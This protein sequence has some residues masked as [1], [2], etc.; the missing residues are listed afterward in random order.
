[1]LSNVSTWGCMQYFVKSW[2][3]TTGLSS[4]S[5]TWMHWRL[6]PQN[7]T[8]AMLHNNYDALVNITNW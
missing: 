2:Q 8:T 3:K 5:L 4:V 1:M 6:A 7:R